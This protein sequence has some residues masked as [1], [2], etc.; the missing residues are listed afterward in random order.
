MD[1]NIKF[2]M[3]KIKEA[4]SKLS[5]VGSYSV[6]LVPV[7]LIIIAVLLLGV[8]GFLN[9]KLQ[10]KIQKNSIKLADSVERYSSEPL[11]AKQSQVEKQYQDSLAADVNALS[12]LMI[13]STKRELLSYQV[14][15]LPKSSSEQVYRSFGDA[16]RQGIRNM[17]ESYG[18]RSGP[19]TVEIEKALRQSSPGKKISASESFSISK[20]DN[21]ERMIVEEICQ[22]AA[23]NASFYASAAQIPGYTYWE[24]IRGEIGAD[25]VFSFKNQEQAVEDCWYWQLGYWII[26]DVL[27]TIDSMNSDCSSVIDCPVKRLMKLSF[28]EEKQQSGES[29]LLRPSYIDSFKNSMTV[30]HTGRISN[31]QF[32]IVQFQFTVVVDRRATLSF[33]EQLCTA[34][35]HIFRGFSGNE[36]PGNF[37]HNQITILEADIQPVSFGR[38]HELYRYGETAVAELKIICEYVFDRPGYDEIKPEF[39][40]NPAQ[41]VVEE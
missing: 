17:L 28:G 14:F 27:K 12:R 21:V 32:D 30:A 18:A 20:L 7:V 19:S 2:D 5:F 4:L 1:L 35:E 26:E 31:E 40:K 15:P 13:Q 8:N 39:I 33:M 16:Y 6:F 23:A 9:K 41:Q 10:A 25:S 38:E 24:D 36:P 37:R 22:S 11:S 3:S 29:K 34:K